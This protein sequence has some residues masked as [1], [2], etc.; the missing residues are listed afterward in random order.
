MP[1]L[2]I[3]LNSEDHAAAMQIK[4]TMNLSRVIGRFIR[5]MAESKV[6]E[7]KHAKEEAAKA[8]TVAEG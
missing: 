2:T 5:I 1:N 8:A 6:R 3:Y 4:G 7:D